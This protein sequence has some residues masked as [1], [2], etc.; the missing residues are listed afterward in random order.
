MLEQARNGQRV[1][2]KEVKRKRQDGTYFPTKASV[3]PL[4][5]HNEEVEA[6]L[7]IS[8]DI[9]K[10]KQLEE[11]LKEQISIS[12]TI[13]NSLPG[14]FYMMDE[15]LN[16]VRVN[17][18]VYDFFNLSKGTEEK[19]DPLSLILPS[20]HLKVTKKIAEVLETGYAEIETIMVSGKKEYNFFINGKLLELGDVKYIL[21]NGINITDRV[22]TQK[23][24]RVLLQ[25]VHHRVKNNLAII[26]GLLSM[27]MEE[28]DNDE[29]KLS[30][31]R[32][33]N[34]IQSMAKVHELL[35][36]TEDFSSVSIVRYLKELSSIIQITF[37]Q[38]QAVDINI[39]I[40]Q[41]D[42]NINEAIPLG[43]LMNELLT[44][45]LK[46]AFGDNGGNITIRIERNLDE[47]H[48]TYC[49]NGKG[50]TVKPDLANASSLGFT[51]I[52]TLLQQLNA[53]FELNV[54]NKFE[55]IFTFGRKMKGSHST[56]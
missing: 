4:I 29:A 8:E 49:D 10:Q 26:S 36:D 28:F 12:E 39:D 56:L 22:K 32:S 38:S 48:V 53:N 25:E 14:L 21:G 20:E 18:N 7:V 35:Y 1:K 15:N 19:V 50:M 13:L 52:Y 3:A 5:D 42:M 47:Y 55:L 51:I 46:Y 30:F 44:N 23:K 54:D 17:E 41:I 43:M 31:Q 27:E 6:I 24:N 9:T 34:R 2:A 16:F 37:D 33:I 40:E 45:S 11:D